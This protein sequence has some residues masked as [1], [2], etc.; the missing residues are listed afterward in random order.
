[1]Q[2]NLNQM[3]WCIVD[4]IRIIQRFEIDTLQRKSLQIGF[5]LSKACFLLAVDAPKSIHVDAAIM[6]TETHWIII[7]KCF[8]LE[9]NFGLQ[10]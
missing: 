10:R 3:K 4:T 7:I 6:N 1:M 5:S 9:I 8:W 2:L